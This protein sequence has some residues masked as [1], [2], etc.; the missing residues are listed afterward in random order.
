MTNLNLV[1]SSEVKS[2][3]IDEISMVS[4]DL[5]IDF[6]PKLG[7]IFMMI[8]EIAQAGLSVMTVA[9]LLQLLL[10]RGNLI[11]SQFS[12]KDSMKRLLGLQLW[13]LFKYRELTEVVRQNHKL[14]VIIMSR[15]RFRVNPHSIVDSIRDMIITYSRMHRTDKYSQHS[16]IIWPAWLNG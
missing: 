12:H 13:H 3:I 15:T 8:P 4:S 14:Y 9:D 10:V 2:F 1:K 5:C 6:D 11:F 16:S 7:E